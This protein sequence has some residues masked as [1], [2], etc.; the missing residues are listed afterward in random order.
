MRQSQRLT[1]SKI[2]V[3]MMRKNITPDVAV[4]PRVKQIT[5]KQP[6]FGTHYATNSTVGRCT[7][8]WWQRFLNG[9]APQHILTSRN[10]RKSVIFFLPRFLLCTLPRSWDYLMSSL[11]TYALVA[12]LFSSESQ[13]FGRGLQLQKLKKRKTQNRSGASLS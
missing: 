5:K 8:F 13:L 6:T 1:P 10:R 7:F 9:G 11:N 3:R 4:F 2:F 12:V